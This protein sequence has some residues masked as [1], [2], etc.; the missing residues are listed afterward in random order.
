MMNRG[1]FLLISLQ[2][3]CAASFMLCSKVSLINKVLKLGLVDCFMNGIYF[4][5]WALNSYT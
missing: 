3:N 1:S 2:N 5:T 4:I